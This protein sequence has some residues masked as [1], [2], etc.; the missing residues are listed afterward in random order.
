[1][2]YKHLFLW[3]I[4]FLI[5]VGIFIFIYN[6]S[7]F[8]SGKESPSCEKIF[9]SGN[10]DEKIDII[11]FTKGVSKN[12]IQNYI[13]SLFEF[14]PFDK[15]RDNF[16]FFYLDEKINCDLK[17]SALFCYSLDLV[18]KSSGCPNDFVVVISEESGGVRSS[19]YMNVISI[20]ENLPVSVF[21]HE[22]AH[23]FANL[24][25]EYVPAKIPFASKNCAKN[26]EE[27]KGIGGCFQ[28]CSEA[29]FFRSSENSIMRT[30]NSQSYFEFNQKIILE[31]LEKW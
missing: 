14:E 6:P 17:Y 24:A 7:I 12:K 27:F 13:D 23:I 4:I 5:V 29:N 15:Q 25:D 30:L 21:A 20:N 10:P 11:F 26:C 31:E 16:N 9:Y 3:G 19:A 2:E 1:M 18:Q 22:F 8:Y 28:E